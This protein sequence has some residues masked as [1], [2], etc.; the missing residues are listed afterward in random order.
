MSTKVNIISPM[1]V[2]SWHDAALAETNSA[3]KIISRDNAIL[4]TTTIIFLHCLL[5]DS[6]ETIRFTSTTTRNVLGVEK[7]TAFHA[8]ALARIKA[9]DELTENIRIA[10][11]ETPPPP[12]S[13]PTP[14]QSIAILA[15]T[16]SAAP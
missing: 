13:D 10:L 11:G 5:R 4:L 12:S 8:Y 3:V 15:G 16:P 2:K 1:L 14:A 9:W 7:G 6:L